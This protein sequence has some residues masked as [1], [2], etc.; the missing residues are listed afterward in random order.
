MADPHRIHQGKVRDVYAWNDTLLLVATD[1]ISAFDVILPTPIPDKGIALTQLSRYWFDHLP[2]GIPSHVIGFELPGGLDRPEWRRRTTHCHRA[3]VVPLE[4]VVR[5]YLAGSGWASYRETGA[6][7]G[8]S[9]PAG[10]EESCQ[11]P[12]PI[13][14][15]TTKAASGH[16]EPLTEDQAR[17]HV[18][19]EVYEQLKTMSLKL[20]RWAHQHAL[21]RG[22]IIADTK[23]EFGWIDG[24]L[25][26]VDECLTSDSS[27]YWPQADYRP[28]GPQKAFDKQ[29]VRDYLNSL[30]DWNR[31]P[32]G[33][34]LP[35]DVVATTRERYIEAY[36]I[37]TGDPFQA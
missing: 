24:R 18:G 3:E 6:V 17:Q 15:P 16:D 32:P 2:D 31:Q 4:C 35:E 21:A 12:D 26:L 30:P 19:E 27:R 9:L 20:Y 25:S 29:F 10:L 1:R 13:F 28:G 8:H 37:I 5:G 7:Q 34:E 11:L 33:P 36:Q 14:T 23:F 22:L